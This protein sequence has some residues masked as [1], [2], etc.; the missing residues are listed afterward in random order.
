MIRGWGKNYYD[1]DV[2]KKDHYEEG[3]GRPLIYS[4]YRLDKRPVYKDAMETNKKRFEDSIV[5][6]IV[7]GKSHPF[8]DEILS[9]KDGETIMLNKKGILGGGD[10]WDK[11]MDRLDGVFHGDTKQSLAD[12]SAKLRST[13]TVRATRK[14]NMVYLDGVVDHQVNDV[15]DFNKDD[16][17]YSY[18][19]KKAETGKAKPYGTHASKLERLK[20]RILVQGG[21]IAGYKFDWEPVG[22]MNIPE[23]KKGGLNRPLFLI[24]ALLVP[25]GAGLRAPQSR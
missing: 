13:G 18:Y 16:H 6:G 4:P 22:P 17:E 2:V 5:K 14:G 10:Y 7:D 25:C 9:L 19:R 11:D 8:K 24:M 12:G 15:Y 21:K 1:D 23:K 20:G 3:S